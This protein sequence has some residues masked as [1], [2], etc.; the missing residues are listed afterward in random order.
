M[1]KTSLKYSLYSLSAFFGGFALYSTYQYFLNKPKPI[2]YKTLLK[3]TTK[4]NAQIQQIIVQKYGLN[5]TTELTSNSKPNDFS[6]SYEQTTPTMDRLYIALYIE[7]AQL[8]KL[9]IS[10]KD[11]YEHLSKYI[12]LKE[13]NKP[14]KLT[15]KIIR[16]LDK[17]ELPKLQCGDILPRKYIE[18]ICNIYY[19]NLQKTAREFYDK[20]QNQKRQSYNIR[21]NLF[22]SIYNKYLKA[23][24]KEVQEFFGID[25]DTLETTFKV[26]LRIYP[27]LLDK[28]DPVKKEYDLITKSVND[29][30]EYIVKKEEPVNELINNEHPKCLKPYVDH[31]I[32]FMEYIGNDTLQEEKNYEDLFD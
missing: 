7:Q 15:Q 8:K 23:T 4:T 28:D 17:G 27:Y 14:I 29:L 26:I 10:E 20:T 16:S 19:F 32:N 13:I 11:F 9:N 12:H 22:N 25:D 31:K 2:P 1:L 21:N 5:T 6:S 18:I 3:I 30:I 24:R